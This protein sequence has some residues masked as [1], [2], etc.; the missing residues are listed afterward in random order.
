MASKRN[1]TLYIG[2][3]S[4]LI[5]TVWEHKY[6]LTESFTQKYDVSFLAYYE[7]FD[8]VNDA[9]KRE[10]QLKNW[11]R[12]WKIELIEKANPQWEDLYKTLSI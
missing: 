11:R 3:A 9:I 10:K 8:N 5:I 1:G 6:K 12:K 2:I 7:V 4:N